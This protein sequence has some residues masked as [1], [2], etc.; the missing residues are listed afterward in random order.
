MT[1]SELLA[2][3][4]E[5]LSPADQLRKAADLYETC[6]QRLACAVAKRFIHDVE[7]AFLIREDTPTEPHAAPPPE[8]A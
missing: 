6:Q 5:N 7:L 4:I 2:R 3:E 1:D 8:H